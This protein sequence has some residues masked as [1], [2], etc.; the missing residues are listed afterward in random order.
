MYIH[1]LPCKGLKEHVILPSLM[2]CSLIHYYSLISTG[3]YKY[4]N[5]IYIIRTVYIGN[6]SYKGIKLRACFL[7]GVHTFCQQQRVCSSKPTNDNNN[8]N[9][10]NINIFIILTGKYITKLHSIILLK[11]LPCPESLISQFNTSSVHNLCFCEVHVWTYLSK[12][13]EILICPV[14]IFNLLFHLAHVLLSI[15]LR[16][17]IHISL[18]EKTFLYYQD[19]QK[20]LLYI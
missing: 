4:K 2:Q 14:I 9:D 12:I 17:S 20:F 7:E 19:I 10:N 8:D 6:T 1:P 16:V 11:S 18:Y 13:P 3:I 15:C 5:I